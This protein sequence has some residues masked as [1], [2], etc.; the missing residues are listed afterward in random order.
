MSTNLYLAAEGA[1]AA[2]TTGGIWSEWAGLMLIGPML[3]FVVIVLFGKRMR[4]QGA[5]VAIGAMAFNF[6]WSSVLL[7]LNMGDS[8]VLYER[9]LEIAAVGGGLV[10]ELGWI[11]DGLSIM[12]Y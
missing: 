10:F 5:E 6:V 4:Y 1:A 7:L 8:G 2:A 9:S 11:V 12:M 3:A